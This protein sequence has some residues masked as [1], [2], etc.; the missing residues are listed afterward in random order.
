MKVRELQEVLMGLDPDAEVV[1]GECDLDAPAP[2]RAE[3]V[4]FAW[5]ARRYVDGLFVNIKGPIENPSL[6]GG[7]PIYYDGEWR[8]VSEPVEGGHT[9]TFEPFKAVLLEV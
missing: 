3:D 1:V 9:I 5:C 4:A 6:G 8:R 2:L 7:L